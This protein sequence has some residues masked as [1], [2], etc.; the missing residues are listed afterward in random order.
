MEKK[1]I[2][3]IEKFEEKLSFFTNNIIFS[4]IIIG[5]IG[6]SIRILFLDIQIPINSDNY[7][8]FRIAIDQSL[9]QPSNTIGNDGWP[10]FLSLFFKLFLQI[11]SWIIWHYKNFL[12][13]EFQF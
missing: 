5:V 4:L 1:Q 10:Y 7:L 6:L 13:L 9:G 3:I 11:I 8:F 2:S 12:Q